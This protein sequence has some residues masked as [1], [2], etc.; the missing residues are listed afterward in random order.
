MRVSA[1]TVR[2]QS[3]LGMFERLLE[4]LTVKRVNEQIE[5]AAKKDGTGVSSRKRWLHM[6]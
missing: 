6:A 3:D 4:D 1:E 5:Q 2:C